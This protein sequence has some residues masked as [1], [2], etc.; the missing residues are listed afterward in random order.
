MVHVI[1]NVGVVYVVRCD[2]LSSTLSR[3]R[4]VYELLGSKISVSSIK[5]ES[6]LVI[7]TSRGIVQRTFAYGAT[8]AKTLERRSPVI[9]HPLFNLERVS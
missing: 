8:I 2:H 4:N 9:S 1:H 7:E 5:K 6:K 3:T